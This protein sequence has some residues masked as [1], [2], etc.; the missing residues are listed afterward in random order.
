MCEGGSGFVTQI[1]VKTYVQRPP[2]EKGPQE[3]EELP[4]N[5]CG[6]Y[7]N[8]KARRREYFNETD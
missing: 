2:L 4:L 8:R 3:E 5:H 7:F 1:Q 6:C